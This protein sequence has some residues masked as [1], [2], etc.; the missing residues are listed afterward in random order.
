MAKRKAGTVAE[1]VVVEEA[2]IEEAAPVE[3]TKQG[4]HGDPCRGA[5]SLQ[6]SAGTEEPIPPDPA[7]SEGGADDP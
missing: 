2:V 4:L 3:E 5:G 6:G 7:V 1:E